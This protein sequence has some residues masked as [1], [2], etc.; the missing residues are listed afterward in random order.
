VLLE[1]LDQEE[2][3]EV[4]KNRDYDENTINSAEELGLTSVINL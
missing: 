4:A 2:F 3:G 1:L